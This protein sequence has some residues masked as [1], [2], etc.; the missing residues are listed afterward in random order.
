MAPALFFGAEFGLVAE[1]QL[2]RDADIAIS[3][4][5]DDVAEATARAARDDR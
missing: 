5:R 1:V 4:T 3:F 2:S